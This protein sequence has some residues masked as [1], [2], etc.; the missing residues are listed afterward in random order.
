M[1]K[2]N[3][4]DNMSRPDLDLASLQQQHPELWANNVIP[5]QKRIAARLK[6]IRPKEPE[7]PASTTEIYHYHTDHLGTPRELTDTDGHIAWEACYQTWGRAH[8]IDYPGILH[9]ISDGNTQRQVWIEPHPHERPIQ[10]LRFQ[11]QYHDEETGLHYNRFRYYDPDVGRFASQDP[12][13]LAG[14]V[15]T[16]Q[17]APN[18][19]VWIDPLGL[20]KCEPNKKTSYEGV[21]RRDALRQAKRD[22]GI[23]NNQQ[24][25]VSRD[26]LR[27]GSG[28][29][30]L[31]PDGSPV[32]VRQYHYTANDGRSIVIQE[33]SM[34]HAKA[35]KGHGAEPHFNTRPSINV[36]T[37]SVPGTHG[38][39][40]FK[41]RRP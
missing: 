4:P 32:E 29:K 27:D 31:K 13:G 37:G 39:Y 12:I 30:I 17:Y 28:N 6:N 11:G 21:S 2:C 20:C 24:P 18:P 40:N 36:N 22:A 8:Q 10:N 7:R 16:Y 33:H 19:V 9:V 1:G 23:P 35:T 14:G 15:N 34:G 3:D 25:K 5:L 38:H 41:G 26:Y